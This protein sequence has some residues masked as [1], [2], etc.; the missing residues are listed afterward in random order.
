VESEQLLTQGE[1]FKDEILAGMESTNST[2]NEV[3]E[4]HYHG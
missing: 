3:P 2:T 4:P 1:I